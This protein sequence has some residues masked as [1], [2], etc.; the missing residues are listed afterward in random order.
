MARPGMARVKTMLFTVAIAKIFIL[1]SSGESF[2]FHTG[3]VAECMG[4]HNIHDARSASAL[5]AGTDISSTCLDCHGESGAGGYHI[6][7]P[8][9]DMPAGTPPGNMT[10][11]GDFGW[12]KKAYTYSPRAVNVLPPEPAVEPGPV[13][14]SCPVPDRQYEKLHDPEIVSGERRQ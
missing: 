1:L 7:T 13:R 11:G 12:L 4:C 9:A 14:L 3:G 5:L 8:D 10:Q 6:A 2:A